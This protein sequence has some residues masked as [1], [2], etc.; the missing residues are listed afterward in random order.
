[1]KRKRLL[2]KY[3]I[4]KKENL[5]QVI[6]ELKENYQPSRNNYLGTGNSKTSSIKIKCSEQTATNFTAFSGRKIPM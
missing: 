3:N 1:M 6:E 4:E 2:R 5:D